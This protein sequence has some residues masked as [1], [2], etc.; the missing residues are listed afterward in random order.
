[1][2]ARTHML[3]VITGERR[4]T[5][6][7]VAPDKG[8]WL[9]GPPMPYLYASPYCRSS[10]SVFSH[11]GSMGS[12]KYPSGRL[13]RRPPLITNHGRPLY[14]IL[15]PGWAR[16]P[17]PTISYRCGPSTWGPN[18]LPPYPRSTAEPALHEALLSSFF[19]IPDRDKSR[20]RLIAFGTNPAG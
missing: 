2:D 20:R 17:P 11:P 5:L 13:C 12:T 3:G 7:Q 4:K 8:E 9:Q 18:V 16:I 19:R 14:T 15:E 1:M 6:D 10:P